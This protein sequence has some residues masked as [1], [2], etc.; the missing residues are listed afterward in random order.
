MRTRVP[1]ALTLLAAL[2]A[3]GCAASACTKVREHHA[4]FQRRAP[5][6]GPHLA[7]ALPYT[8]LSQSVQRSL[9]RLRGVQVP[10][11][12]LALPQLPGLEIGLG[13]VEVG[14][15]GVAFHAA[16][17]GSLGVKV[18]VALTTRGRQVAALDLDALVAPRLDPKEGSVRVVLRAQDLVQVR[19]SLPP[20][21]RARFADFLMSVVP[22]GAERL[23]SRGR[24]E[25]LADKLLGDLVGGRWPQI[26]DSLLRDAGDLVDVEIDLPT[27]P[28]TRI[29][30][31]SGDADLEL[32]AHASLPAASLSPGPARAPGL[33]PR[34]VV[35]R[36]SGGAAAE[37]ANQAIARGQIP[38]RYDRE[39]EPNPRGEF[40]AGVA[41]ETGERPLKVH[42][43]SEQGTCA[44]LKF[45]GTPRITARG[46]QLDVAVP[47][48]E[49]EKV[50]GSL[51]ARAAVWFSGLGRRTFEFSEAI[52]GAIE[53][54]ALGADYRANVV[55]AAVHGPDVVFA[56]TLAE[57]KRA[58]A[59]SP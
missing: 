38:A 21:E 40:T 50:T 52:A 22:D 8:T 5:Q 14:V 4:S 18:S 19:P 10:L 34:L 41:W 2:T 33:D 42:A 13:A 32:W 28:L 46:D 11:G 56:M 20:A 12:D 24:V 49:L 37:L 54:E 48:G 23:V 15:R 31:R 17:P 27:L 57:A 25:Q 7:L 43:W 36:M 16:P 59:R 51:R 35:L 55:S 58:P 1:L 53:F 3:S 9:A 39:G 47:D 6:P 44:H 26:R 29:E 30:L 45:A